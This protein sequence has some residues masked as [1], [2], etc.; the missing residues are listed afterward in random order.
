MNVDVAN[1]TDCIAGVDITSGDYCYNKNV[2]E[3]YKVSVMLHWVI[4]SHA[5]TVV[6]GVENFVC[7]SRMD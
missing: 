1:P 6:E 4:E 2:D 5:L 7:Y 3:L